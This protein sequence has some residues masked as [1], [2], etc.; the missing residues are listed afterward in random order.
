LCFSFAINTRAHLDLFWRRRKIIPFNYSTLRLCVETKKTVWN[1][2]HPKPF[3]ILRINASW[4]TIQNKTERKMREICNVKEKER[5]RHNR[6]NEWKKHTEQGSKQKEKKESMAKMLKGRQ[7]NVWILT[8]VLN[9][10][11]LI[12]K[13][14]SSRFTYVVHLTTPI[15]CVN[16]GRWCCSDWKIAIET[17]EVLRQAMFKQ[18]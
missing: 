17:N 1:V 4:S 3:H 11:E 5:K 6:E 12:E 2:R 15:F 16:D 9:R 7:K 8:N 10:W 18:D 13:K 14:I